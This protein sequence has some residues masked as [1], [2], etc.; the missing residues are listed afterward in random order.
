MPRPAAG[1]VALLILA[2]ELLH[3]QPVRRVSEV[4]QVASGVGTTVISNIVLVDGRGGPPVENAVVV[5]RDGRIVSAG[6]QVRMPVGAE[7]VDGGGMS[8]LPGLID[9]HFHLD[10]DLGLP[11]LFL[12]HGV[13]AVRDPGAWIEAYDSV[14]SQRNVPRLFLAGPHLDTPP[15]AYPGDSYLVRDAEETKAAVGRF[16]RQGAS[17][18]KAYFRLPLSLVRA[19]TAEAHAL[20][21]PVTAHLEIVDATDATRVGVDGIEHIT[22]FGTSLL[23]PREAERYRQSILADNGARSDGRYR[24]WSTLDLAGPRAQAALD[25]AVRHGT[26]LSPTLAV[27]ERRSGDPETEG[28]HVAGFARMLAFTGQARR[29]GARVV[30]GSHSSVPHAERG[31]AYLREM[32]LLVEAGLTPLQ[33]IAAATSVNARFLRIADRLGTVAPGMQADL[34]LVN[35]RPDQDIKAMGRVARV[36]LNGRWVGIN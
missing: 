13:T 12:R 27:F 36:M 4:N 1:T 11:A 8:L 24:V 23:P 19:A 22:S 28:W 17:V 3:G 20:G 34:I 30:V 7:L 26:Y 35:G 16:V 21:I 14:R 18:I 9:A 10:G 31:F 6:H 15:P 32:E 5:V 29:A 25:L 33:T 2:A